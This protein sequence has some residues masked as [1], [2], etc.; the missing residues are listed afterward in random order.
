M[1]HIFQQ[2]TTQYRQV[3]HTNVVVLFDLMQSFLEL[4]QHTRMNARKDAD[5]IQYDTMDY[6][7]VRPKADK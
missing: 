1:G 2:L 3:L 5:T 7:N 6:I 4:C